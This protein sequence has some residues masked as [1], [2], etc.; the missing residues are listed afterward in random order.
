MADLLSSASLLV[1][2]IAV[3]YGLWYPDIAKGINIEAG[4]YRDD[5]SI[6]AVKDVMF[7]KSLTL[8]ISAV[9]L[10]VV[11]LKDTMRIVWASLSLQP[12]VLERLYNYDAVST[13]FV[14]IEFIWIYVSFQLIRDLV[15]LKNK[16]TELNSKPVF[17][18]KPNP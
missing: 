13:A 9:G 14:F 5:D 2:I 1:A 16:Y 7:R 3:L 4:D 10:A 11:Y 17:V 18:V 6:S 12:T 15:N 8:V